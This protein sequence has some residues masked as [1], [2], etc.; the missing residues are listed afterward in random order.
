MLSFKDF[1]L[2]EGSR[3][4]QIRQ[5]ALEG[6]HFGT[7]SAERKDLSPKENAER[8]NALKNELQSIGYSG[9]FKRSRGMW[10]GGSEASFTVT[11]P[12]TGSKV[13]EKLRQDLIMLGKKYGQDSVLHYDHKDAKLHGTNTTG[14]PGLDQTHSLGRDL[15]F[16]TPNPEGETDFSGHKQDSANPKVKQG[17][18]PK[19]SAKF[20]FYSPQKEE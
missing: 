17:K 13:G 8:T 18:T 15:R 2:L 3:L 5:K 4:A 19:S 9:N 6:R 1:M 14:F 16:N 20:T 12:Q 7:I 11:A 10:E